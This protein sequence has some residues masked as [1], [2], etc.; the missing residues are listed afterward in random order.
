MAPLPE[1]NKGQRTGFFAG[2]TGKA[3]RATDGRTW[4]LQFN[5]LIATA[6]TQTID[7]QL[8]SSVPGFLVCN[9]VLSPRRRESLGQV[10]KRSRASATELVA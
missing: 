6:K 10:S 1:G 3:A 7:E 9:R 2:S 4:H 8:G 5:T